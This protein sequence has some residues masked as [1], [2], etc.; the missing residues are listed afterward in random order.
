MTPER[1]MLVRNSFASLACDADLAAASFYAR[2]FEFDPALRAL[3]HTDMET[4]GRKFIHMLDEVIHAMDRLGQLCPQSGS[5]A[6]GTAA[7]ACARS[8]SR[9]SK[10]RLSTPCGTASSLRS[11]H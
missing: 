11:T 1:K 7:T 9:S 10:P 8:T 2:L 4:Q 3:F 6:S 5:W